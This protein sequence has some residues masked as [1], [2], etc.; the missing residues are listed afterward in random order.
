MEEELASLH[1]NQTWSLVP[2]NPLMNGI[3]SKCV[4]K[5]KLKPD[6]SLDR[7]KAPIVAQG[8]HQI[9]GV[10]YTETFSLVVKPGTIRMIITIGLVKHWTIQQLDVRNAFLH[11]LPSEDIYMEQSPDMTDPKLPHHHLQV[12]FSDNLSALHMTIKPVF[13]ARGKHIELDYRFVRE[14]VAFRHLITQHISSTDQVADLFSK[15]FSKASML[16]FQSKLCL[17]PRL[18]LWAHHNSHPPVKDSSHANV[19]TQQGFTT[20]IFSIKTLTTTLLQPNALQSR[21]K[22]MQFATVMLSNQDGNSAEAVARLSLHR[23]PLELV[24]PKPLKPLRL[25]IYAAQGSLDNEIKA[26]VKSQVKE[27]LHMGEY[28]DFPGCSNVCDILYF[29]VEEKVA[30]FG[31][32]QKSSSIAILHRSVIAF[33]SI[34]Q[35]WKQV[36]MVGFCGV[37]REDAIT[38]VERRKGAQGS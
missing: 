5:T 6:G 32:R 33:F 4:F 17:Q 27:D 12:L 26:A 15:P 25:Y 20:L 37:E 10:D 1:Q 11:G 21:W 18:S 23:S 36:T 13:Y 29:F 38:G 7:L 31:S 22:L 34:N 14:R 28:A 9:D 35:F 16:R 30:K 8:F 3:G 24:S 2:C 19:F